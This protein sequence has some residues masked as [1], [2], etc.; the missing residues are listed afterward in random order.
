MAPIPGPDGGMGTSFVGGGDL[1]VFQESDNADAAWKYVQWLSQPDTQ[2]AFYEEVGDL[3]AVPAAWES[4]ELAK[5][6]QLQVFGQQLEQTV[7]PPAVPTWEQ[8]AGSIDT[9]VEQASKGD[10]PADQAVNQMQSEAES[11]G[12]GL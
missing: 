2:Q 1:A 5:D 4:G 8:V 11:I 12:T 10:L 3:P 9:I 7:A 6:P